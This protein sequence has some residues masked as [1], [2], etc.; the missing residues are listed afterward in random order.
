MRLPSAAL[1][2]FLAAPAAAQEAGPYVALGTRLD[3][4]VSWAQDA[5]A[6]ARSLDPLVR[7]YRLDQLVSAVAAE[8]TIALSPAALRAFYDVRAELRRASDPS[9]LV[10]EVG[11]NAHENGRRDTFRPGGG[12]GFRPAGGIWASLSDGPFVAVVN[13][14]FE[15][16]LRDDPEFT[17]YVRPEIAGRMQ[18]AYLAVMGSRG[19]L[20]LGRM[21]RNWGPTLFDGLLVSP[22]AYAA[23]ALAGSLTIGRFTL[24]ALARRL[25]DDTT[26]SGTPDEHFNRYF[27]AHRLSVNAGRGVWLGLT[28]A[29]VYGGRGQSWQPAF[30]APL[31]LGILSEFNE[32]L[33]V[34]LLLGADV[35]V[36]LGGVQL[37]GSLMLDDIQV[38][39]SIITDQRPASYA[40][41]LTAR[42]VLPATPLHA[43]LGYTRVSSIAYRNGIQPLAYA[44]RWVGL[45]RAF[46]DYDQWLLRLAARPSPDWHVAL[47]LTRIRQG[48]G[49]L[50][51]PLPSDSALARPGMGFL[52][53][54]VAHA[55]GARVTVDAEPWRG[56]SLRGE[57]GSIGGAAILGVAAHF[58][59]DA[60]RR[61][62]G[63][64]WRGVESGALRGWP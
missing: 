40:L 8:D 59:F 5:G 7:P 38:D 21:S 37:A 6:F 22:S 26:I 32:R 14:A 25:D 64:P 60:L 16:R 46:T 19:D 51:D 52:L 36:R 1:M 27:F 10:A 55:N 47:D 34:N 42:A 43:A 48:A 24:H 56:V 44:D 18:A 62:A 4:L 15:E 20:A 45:G 23:D 41:A 31:N 33:E 63:S 29:G 49:A 28:E 30:H 35:L 57:A 61:T 58:T 17:G 13:P 2:L 54:P 9:A 11:F 3:R 50:R 12:D 53:P 39:D